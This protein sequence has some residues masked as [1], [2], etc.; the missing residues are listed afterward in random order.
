M[1]QL[2][3]IFLIIITIGLCTDVVLAKAQY[4]HADYRPHAHMVIA[5]IFLAAFFGLLVYFAFGYESTLKFFTGYV[6]E[7]SLSID[8]LFV[9]MTIFSYFHI[10][11]E[12]QQK[13][14]TY[15]MVGAMAMRMVFV[16]AGITLLNKFKWLIHI[17]GV[18]LIISAIGMFKSEKQRDGASNLLEKIKTF[19][20]IKHS[21]DS[22]AFFTKCGNK[23]YATPLLACVI[24]IEIVDIIFA[25]DSV[26][27]VL[28][29]T[30][31]PILVYSSNV[32]AIVGLRSLYI[33]L[34]Q[35][36]NKFHLLQYG[37]AANLVFVGTN[38][39]FSEVYHIPTI[40][41]TI[42]IISIF[43]STMAMSCLTTKQRR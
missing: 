41:N 30:K 1:W 14:L 37:I 16:L 42:A 31:I 2:W 27:A 40:V 29:I 11:N 17:F 34:T 4:T 20:K 7:L 5:W 28:S 36:I 8:N 22:L 38:M 6:L 15:G 25:V 12:A 3:G 24:T 18:V 32:F 21:E 39:I 23:W 13:A 35:L 26:P 10:V 9:F 43:L 19:L 33:C